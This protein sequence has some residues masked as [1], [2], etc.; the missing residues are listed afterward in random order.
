MC[1]W[2]NYVDLTSQRE[3]LW[4][5][6]IQSKNKVFLACW[7]KKILVTEQK[8]WLRQIKPK[9][10]M[11]QDIAT[12][13]SCPQGQDTIAALFFPWGQ[14]NSGS[15]GGTRYRGDKINWY[16]GNPRPHDPKSG[17]QTTRPPWHFYIPDWLFFYNYF[18]LLLSKGLTKTKIRTKKN[19]QKKKPI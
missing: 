13:V 16:T 5:S 10:E 19:K 12:P 8:N 9:Q 18:C 2:V 17:V 11:G 7:K 4:S 15:W 6:I 3:T 14:N 1:T